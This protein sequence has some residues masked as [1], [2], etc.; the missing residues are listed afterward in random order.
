MPK[1][2]QTS[3][4]RRLAANRANAQLS[5]GPKT[6]AGKAKSSLNAVKTGLTGRTVVLPGEDAERYKSHI[7][8]FRKALKPVGV[9]EEAVA[10][11]L[12]DTQWRLARIPTLES[13]ILALGRKRCAPDLFADEPDPDVRAVLME[14]HVFDAEAKTLKNLYLQESRLRRQYA[15]DLKEL[16]RLREERKGAD[17][18]EYEDEEFDEN[19]VER[20]QGDD[21]EDA[22]TPCDGFEFSNGLNH[23]VSDTSG[24][25]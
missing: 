22:S 19:N 14:A 25:R 16:E 9:L 2:S 21:D 7:E 15:Q 8:R 13:G 5:S 10:R 11:R 1:A 4:E 24:Q 6:D 12:A 23:D 3:S 17:E 18:E 20:E